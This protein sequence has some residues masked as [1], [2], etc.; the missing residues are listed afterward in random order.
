MNRIIIY[1]VAVFLS[2]FLLFFVQPMVAKALLPVFG[3]SYMVWGACMV[4][5]QGLLLGGYAVAHAGQ[6][7]LGVF[8]AARWYWLFLLLS[9]GYLPFHFHLL[10]S[11][12]SGLPI[13]LN[14]TLKLLLTVGL[15]FFTLSMASLALQRWLSVSDLPQRD[16]PYSLYSPSN[17]GSILALLLYPAVV[18]PLLPLSGQRTLWWTGYGVLLIL[19]W[20]CMPRRRV[21]REATA[22]DNAHPCPLPFRAK[23]RW[24][25]AT[26]A[27]SAMSLAATNVI[28]LDI[29][30]IPFLWVLPLTVYL[31]TFVVLFKRRMWFP[32]WLEQHRIWALLI[33]LMLFLMS[34][35][36]VGFPTLLSLVL[37]L[38]T[39]FVICMNC[40]ALLVR[41]KP[42][43]VRQLTLFYLFISLGGF[44][45]S[46]FINWIV[47]LISHS[48][49]EYLTALLLAAATFAAYA[50]ADGKK[51]CFALKPFAFAATGAVISLLLIPWLA[52][53]VWT[54]SE[55]PLFLLVLLPIL[56]AALSLK[57][58]PRELVV[59]LLLA[60]ALQHWTER[61]LLG[62][63]NM[64]LH[65]NFY[66]IYKIYDQDGIRYI[67]HGT[68]MHGRQ[69]IDGGKTNIPL[70]Y[71]H[72]AAPAGEL[73]RSGLLQPRAVGM[74]GLGAGALA[75]YGEPDQRFVIY[76]LDP[77]NER[78]AEENF[79]YLSQ[80]RAR[81][82]HLDFV[83]GDGRI[84]LRREKDGAL[85]LLILDAFSS[86]SVPVHLLTVEAMREY[87]R[88][89]K[90]DGVILLNVSNRVLDLRPLIFSLA[91]ATQLHALVKAYMEDV[92]PDADS[93]IWMLVT[94][95]PALARRIS[96]KL[97]W[98]TDDL[99]QNDLPPPWTDQFSNLFRL[100]L[101]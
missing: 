61:M 94:R 20:G 37:H 57:K 28:T 43:D 74:L 26:A 70:A 44:S 23:G 36:R 75:L 11:A 93:C 34:V 59:F 25:L 64:K 31:A 1:Q 14:V 78:I 71:H 88:V 51:P 13:F 41:S 6:R 15:P 101:R 32:A 38:L 48:L 27:A 91:R 5:F 4:F 49:I 97:G 33:G 83:I 17:A 100:L 30:A 10:E 54:L 86:D 89:V 82:M 98:G 46:L 8:R 60:L 73:L 66:G 21:V 19:L 24:F 95:D 47:P 50:S 76:E 63:G 52:G 99:A 62:A 35:I 84:S 58:R 81:G 18:E 80:A 90:P 22:Q 42:A 29:A 45:G 9:L 65:R 69:Y 72:P 12:G 39:L 55:A 40:H 92:H 96:E 16:N 56:P 77:D 67:K 68:T 85:D 2:A 7:K 3:G 87:L 79:T 53:H